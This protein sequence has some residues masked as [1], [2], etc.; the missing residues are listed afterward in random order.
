MARKTG[1]L[2]DEYYYKHCVQEQNLPIGLAQ[3]L[4]PFQRNVGAGIDLPKYLPIAHRRGTM[5][6]IAHSL[7]KQSGRPYD[8]VLAMMEEQAKRVKFKPFS[9]LNTVVDRNYNNQASLLAVKIKPR[10]T[11][12]KQLNRAYIS[13]VSGSVMPKTGRL[14]PEP[15]PI[16]VGAGEPIQEGEDTTG[17]TRVEVEPT[18]YMGP[19]AKDKDEP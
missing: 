18:G 19:P 3:K 12:F 5:G 4:Y 6:E 16:D 1:I 10:E 8:Q 9:N 17:M 15:E 13:P 7:A 14:P 2:S 11:D